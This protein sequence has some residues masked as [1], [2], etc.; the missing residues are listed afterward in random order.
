MDYL[1]K[2]QLDPVRIIAVNPQHSNGC[3]PLKD[4]LF[5]AKTKTGIYR[6]EQQI[7]MKE[8]LKLMYLNEGRNY[9]LILFKIY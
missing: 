2:K 4:Q 3:V 6:K 1:Q 8:L 9:L 5:L 7:A